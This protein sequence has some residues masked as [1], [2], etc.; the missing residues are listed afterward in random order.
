MRVRVKVQAA[1]G[2]D[3]ERDGREVARHVPE[4]RHSSPSRASVRG[5]EH[6]RPR[7]DRTHVLEVELVARVDGERAAVQ[8][9]EVRPVE[10]D[11]AAVGVS[12][13]GG[14]DHER[15]AREREVCQAVG[16]VVR[17]CPRRE[18]DR[19]AVGDA[20]A[21]DVET[22]GRGGRAHDAVPV[23]RRPGVRHRDERL[24]RTPRPGGDAALRETVHDDRAAGIGLPGL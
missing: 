9:E 21:L 14:I 22:V 4:A 17:S 3:V 19:A 20:R 5:H 13:G 6:N 15:V 10:D 1:I 11:E 2:G 18:H 7:T 24:G 23:E 8:R 16:G 12:S